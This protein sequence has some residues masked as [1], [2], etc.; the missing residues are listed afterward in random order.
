[1]YSIILPAYNEAENLNLIIDKIYDLLKDFNFEIIVID[2]GSEDDTED[3]INSKKNHFK[4][5]IFINRKNKKRSLAKSIYEGFLASSGDFIIVMDCDFN[6]NPNYLIDLI[7]LNKKF[8]YDLI[9]CSRYIDKNVRINEFR[10]K[11]S[12]LYNYFL[13]FILNSMIFDNLSGFFLIKKNIL[14]MVDNKKIFFG[15][16]D[17]Y[18]RLLYFLQRMNIKIY[19]FSVI[20]DKRK[21][22]QSKTRFLR[23]FIK[24]TFEV[25]KFLYNGKN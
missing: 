18:F 12:K 17:Y 5:I 22:G 8:D 10:Y 14:D 21:F 9:C 3:L 1:M 15:Y 23:V 16:G 25:L 6:H 20:Y 11:L 13:R 7:N 2:D 19:E 4:N 24:Y